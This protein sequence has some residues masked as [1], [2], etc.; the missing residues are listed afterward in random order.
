MPT[1]TQ[2]QKIETHSGT[3]Q[4]EDPARGT[5]FKSKPPKESM[6]ICE[7]WLA[8][9]NS[10]AEYGREAINKTAAYTFIW[11]SWC[12]FLA[13]RQLD[14]Q[15]TYLQAKPLLATSQDIEQFLSSGPQSSK[16]KR[17]VSNVTKRRYYT[18]LQRIYA[19]C[20]L[21]EWIPLSPVDGMANNDRPS[22]EKH[23]GYVMNDY[24][25]RASIDFIQQMGDTST[26]KRDKAILLLL[27]TLGLRPQ[28]IRSLQVQ[29]FYTGIADLHTIVIND[30]SG[31][32][33]QRSLPLDSTTAKALTDWIVLRQQLPVV[34]KHG[35]KILADRSNEALRAEGQRLFVARTSMHLSMISLLNLVR[36]HIE[37]ACRHASVDPPARMGP[38][39]IRNTRIV[40]WLAAGMDVEEVVRRAGLKNAKGLLHIIHACPDS[41]R[42]EILPSQRR[43]DEPVP[44]TNEQ[45]E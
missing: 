20:A 34:L 4:S 35:K 29:D 22:P 43:D 2:T 12:N 10:I 27:F 30:L 28:E 1:D 9:V 21:Q 5:T 24:Q 37:Q 7:A 45:I 26:E 42:S 38:Q 32:A 16:P 11:R 40:R 36:S 33:Q 18:V 39:I 14:D 3:S 41:V 17:A 13:K 15:A 31:P 19:Y 8:Y 25:W 44:Y 6:Q 23:D